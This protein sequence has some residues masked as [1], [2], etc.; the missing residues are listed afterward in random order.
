FPFRWQKS[1][2]QGGKQESSVLTLTRLLTRAGQNLRR[3]KDFYRHELRVGTKP[4]PQQTKPYI[5][6]RQL[7]RG[8]L[9]DFQ[10][11]FTMSAASN[12]TSRLSSNPLFVP[13]PGLA[14]SLTTPSASNDRTRMDCSLDHL[15][16]IDL[17]D[18]SQ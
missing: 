6:S 15:R 11:S 9:G 18:R 16:E 14:G 8:A 3:A 10:L 2:F 17:R 13:V 7:V 12:E 1:S 4:T 5:A